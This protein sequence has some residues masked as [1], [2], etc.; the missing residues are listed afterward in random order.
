MSRAA[1]RGGQFVKKTDGVAEDVQVVTDRGRRR[2][3][4]DLQS[5]LLVALV[6]FESGG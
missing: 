2:P 5:D 1:G 3:S 4:A 6:Q